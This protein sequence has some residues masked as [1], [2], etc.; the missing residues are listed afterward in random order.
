VSKRDNYLERLQQRREEAHTAAEP[1][2]LAKAPADMTD[3]ERKAEIA[4]L[5][6]EIRETEEEAVRAG[7]EELA[8]RSG[9]AM[10]PRARTRRPYWR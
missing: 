3:A 2:S 6:R 8:G 7:R 10:L 9:R 4:R 5:E 1:A